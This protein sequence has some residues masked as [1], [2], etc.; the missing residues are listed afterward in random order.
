MTVTLTLC[1][2]LASRTSRGL[3][4]TLLNPRCK[5][6]S[7]LTHSCLLAILNSLFYGRHYFPEYVQSGREPHSS[8]PSCIP[9]P[10][11]PA[12]PRYTAP[13]CRRSCSSRTW[14]SS[15]FCEFSGAGSECSDRGTQQGSN[16]TSSLQLRMCAVC[17]NGHLKASWSITYKKLFSVRLIF[18]YPSS[19][20][21]QPW[22]Y[23]Q[24]SEILQVP[25]QT[26]T[27]NQIKQILI[28]GCFCFPVP[29]NLMF[30]PDYRLLSV[31]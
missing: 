30:M 2:W 28:H 3:W 5:N 18:P 21:S 6:N 4:A 24:T 16:G 26:I 12:G 10:P 29:I 8:P 15:H 31:Q 27:I 23:R 7:W 14:I 25:F 9:R 17:A 11:V 13:A 20:V 22:N 19:R 1:F